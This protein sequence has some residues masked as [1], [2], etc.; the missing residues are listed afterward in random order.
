MWCVSAQS[1]DVH[2]VC[3]CVPNAWAANWVALEVI[4]LVKYWPRST[5]Y[6]Q[7]VSNWEQGSEAYIS[8]ARWKGS[9]LARY[10]F[11]L[12]RW[13]KFLRLALNFWGVIRGSL[14][15]AHQCQP[16]A[17]RREVFSRN[18]IVTPLL[19]PELYGT[20]VRLNFSTWNKLMCTPH[21]VVCSD[22]SRPCEIFVAC[23]EVKCLLV[24]VAQSLWTQ[25]AFFTQQG[26][27]P[28]CRLSELNSK[29]PQFWLVS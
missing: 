24:A 3:A 8:V 28:L 2:T 17:Q 4:Y 25:L 19:V 22:C 14:K 9:A 27:R 18:H 20:F 7:H 16:S 12:L 26:A 10:A 23:S 13:R 15:F 21:I 29:E 6:Y 11:L 5:F 1:C